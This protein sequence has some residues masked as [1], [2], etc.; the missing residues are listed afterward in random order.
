M[1]C[2]HFFNYPA[3]CDKS[4]VTPVRIYKLWCGKATNEIIDTPLLMTTMVPADTINR[5]STYE[6]NIQVAKHSTDT[7]T[8]NTI[9]MEIQQDTKWDKAGPL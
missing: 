3:H 7:C 4:S 9:F 8:H 1:A 2:A 6:V 5:E